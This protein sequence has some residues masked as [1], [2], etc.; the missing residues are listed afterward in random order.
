MHI[1]IRIEQSSYLQDLEGD[2]IPSVKNQKTFC[3]IKALRN[4]T[5]Y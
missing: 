5:H 2:E 1:L 3:M 4:S